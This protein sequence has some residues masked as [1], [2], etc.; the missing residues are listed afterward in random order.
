[1][2]MCGAEAVPSGSLDRSMFHD[3]EAIASWAADAVAYCTKVGLMKGNDKGEFCPKDTAT[4]A[5]FATIMERLIEL[6]LDR[7]L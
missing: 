7:K 3:G 5:E 6:L 1:C 2:T 4:R